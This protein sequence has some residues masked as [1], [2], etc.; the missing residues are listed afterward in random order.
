MP[1]LLMLQGLPASGKTTHA[2]IL[3]RDAGWVRVNKDD[4]RK[5]LTATGWTWSK[6]REKDVVKIRDERIGTALQLGR[7][8]VSDDTNFGKHPLHLA[9][10]AKRHGAVFQQFA[11]TTDV[12]ECIQR[13]AARREGQVGEA[14]IRRMWSQYLTPAPETYTFAPV[15]PCNGSEAV[16]C[17][18][19]GT[20]ALHNGRDPYDAS[21][22]D[23]DLVNLP[24]ARAIRA[25]RYGIGAQVLFVSGREERFRPQTHIFLRK[26]SQDDRW[27]LSPLFMRRTGDTRNDWI[28]KGELFDAHIRDKYNVLFCLDDR[29]RVVNFWRSIGLTCFQVAPGNF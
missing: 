10:L 20:L 18:L 21:T 5:E 15:T 8:V 6:E 3:E 9:Q 29:D 7:D 12:E 24:V 28:I 14:V 26:V 16:I 1:T 19:D 17:D 25:L 4:I 23:Q 27:D 13:D 11:H 22:C 2:K